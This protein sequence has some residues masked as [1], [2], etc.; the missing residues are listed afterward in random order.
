MGALTWEGLIGSL[1]LVLFVIVGLVAL[2]S[3]AVGAP[4]FVFVEGVG[5]LAS[6]PTPDFGTFMVG[7]SIATVLAFLGIASSG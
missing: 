1:A 3:M 6:I 5:S 7:V 4:L 2:V